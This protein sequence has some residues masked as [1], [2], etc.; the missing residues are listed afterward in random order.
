MTVPAVQR[1]NPSGAY[2]AMLCLLP[3]LCLMLGWSAAAGSPVQTTAEK[4]NIWLFFGTGAV[5]AAA[6][7]YLVGFRSYIEAGDRLV[8][9]NAI[10]CND[11]CWEDVQLVCPTYWGIIVVG[12]D[13]AQ[14]RGT[15]V[16][17]PNWAT[18][19]GRRVRADEICAELAARAGTIQHRDPSDL[20]CQ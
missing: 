3:A 17:K 16:Q 6:I 9:Q 12:A 13:G 1:W 20:V 19:S 18:S 10:R 7:A 14:A 4:V 11:F 2:R 8:L 5:V 15:A